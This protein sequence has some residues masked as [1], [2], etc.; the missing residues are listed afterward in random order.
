MDQLIPA[1]RLADIALQ[2]YAQQPPFK[3]LGHTMTGMDGAGF[4][5][6]CFSQL[7]ITVPYN[8][9]NTLYR[10]VG[11]N[12]M[13]LQSA[14]AYGKVLP[15]ALLFCVSRDGGEPE[16]YRSDGLGNAEFAE[17]CVDPKRAVYVSGSKKKL[18]ET[19][20]ELVSGK[21]NTVV[22]HPALNYGFPGSAVPQQPSPILHPPSDQFHRQMIVTGTRQLRLRHSPEIIA[23]NVYTGLPSGTL[24]DVLS[25]ENGWAQLTATKN[26]RKYIG[27]AVLDYLKDV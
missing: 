13:S 4:I 8:G 16:R 25:I 24:V 11:G 26:G 22:F 9:T 20:I 3:K 23:D 27:W 7:G 6:Y 14:M 15:G 17:I 1:S 5:S 18:I 12:R 21:A 10:A 19:K 2:V